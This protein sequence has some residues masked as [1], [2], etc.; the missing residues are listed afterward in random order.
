MKFFGITRISNFI[1]NPRINSFHANMFHGLAER[2]GKEVPLDTKVYANSESPSSLVISRP[3]RHVPEICKPSSHLVV[4]ERYASQLGALP[5]NRLMPVVFNRL[6]DVDYGAGD[7]SWAEK[8]ETVDPRQLLRTLP[9]VREFHHHIGRYYEVQSYRWRDVVGEYP[10][11]R[12]ITIE[13]GTPPMHETRIIRLSP[14]MLGEY[15]ILL[16]FGT[17]FLSERAF[18][19]LSDGIDRDYFL[20]REYELV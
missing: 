14:E 3:G 12:E 16:F 2:D 5:H 17:A 10:A 15:P 8:W 1:D 6:V 19:I 7:S 11:A 9:D 20:V 13:G 18:E 4:S